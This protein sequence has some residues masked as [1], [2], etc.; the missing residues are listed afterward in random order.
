MSNRADCKSVEAA[1]CR[2]VMQLYSDNWLT[3]RPKG[4]VVSNEHFY[5]KLPEVS[6]ACI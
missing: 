4:K 3:V 1:F 6:A 2:H 5:G